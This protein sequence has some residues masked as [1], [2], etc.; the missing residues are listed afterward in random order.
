MDTQLAK[1]LVAVYDDPTDSLAIMAAADRAEEV[2]DHYA[3]CLRERGWAPGS[4]LKEAENTLYGDRFRESMNLSD[5]NFVEHV[6]ENKDDAAYMMYLFKHSHDLVRQIIVTTV[7]SGKS[8]AELVK[9]IDYNE[10]VATRLVRVAKAM[11]DRAAK[12][13]LVLHLQRKKR[14]KYLANG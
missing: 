7:R 14:D 1:L 13:Y 10:H 5:R 6:R 11:K 12:N 3:E 9:A 4:A 2:G 8:L